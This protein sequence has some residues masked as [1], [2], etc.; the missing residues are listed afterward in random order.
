MISGDLLIR[1]MKID[2]T[3]KLYAIVVVCIEL[4]SSSNEGK[5]TM[6]WLL[7]YSNMIVCTYHAYQP[8][9]KLSLDSDICQY[10]IRLICD[11][12]A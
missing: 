11:I 8:A 7:V 1:I 4:M 6:Q 5:L 2:H 3:V 12:V 9:D 10:K